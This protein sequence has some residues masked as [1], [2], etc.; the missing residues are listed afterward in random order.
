[1][2]MG[3]L[4]VLAFLLSETG[5]ITLHGDS[6]KICIVLCTLLRCSFQSLAI[7]KNHKALTTETPLK[8]NC[9]RIFFFLFLFFLTRKA[10]LPHLTWQM[11]CFPYFMF[12]V[13]KRQWLFRAFLH[14]SVSEDIR[15]TE[16]PW[17]MSSSGP[18]QWLAMT[19]FLPC[20]SLLNGM[21]LQLSSSWNCKVSPVSQPIMTPSK[22]VAGPLMYFAPCPLLYLAKLWEST[23]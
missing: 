22:A 11:C 18:G 6:S 2:E 9:F 19:W 7:C 15:Y 21:R 13:S 16:N 8:I 1:M 20:K 14:I 3:V 5:S 4:K 12:S 23:V 17:L 10:P